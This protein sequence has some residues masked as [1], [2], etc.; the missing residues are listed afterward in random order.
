MKLAIKL[1]SKNNRPPPPKRS[2]KQSAPAPSA[3]SPWSPTTKLKILA[4]LV[5][6]GALIGGY[7]VG[8]H[9]PLYSQPKLPSLSQPTSQRPSVILYT[10]S[11]CTACRNWE[12]ALYQSLNGIMDQVDFKV[13]YYFGS[14]TNLVQYCR[15]TRLS[16]NLCPQIYSYLKYASVTDCALDLT[17]KLTSCQ[18]P[19]RYLTFPDQEKY[20]YSSSSRP[21]ASQNLRFLCAQSLLSPDT[22]WKFYLSTVNSC[23]PADYDL[24]WSQNLVR[25]TENPN[26]LVNCFNNQSQDLLINEVAFAN[27]YP[28]LTLP[29][30][31]IN[32][33][34]A[35]LSS[36]VS[37]PSSLRQLICQSFTHP[38]QAC[39]P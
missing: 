17:Q 4:G 27:Q 12:T 3:P 14:T 39:D 35:D 11:D 26:T 7:L 30:I 28:D 36:F 22:W 5:I 31:L 18:D 37:Q 15:Q 25:L 10:N 34:T 20:Y 16:P 13:H 9:P 32:G 1:M 38:P 6:L 33:R 24:C 19:R 2:A 21:V 8:R 29:S 23:P